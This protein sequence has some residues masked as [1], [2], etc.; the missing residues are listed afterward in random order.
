MAIDL[1]P[2]N[3][4]RY[5]TLSD[6]ADFTLPDSNWTWLALVQRN[7]ASA[8]ANYMLST[9][10]WGDANSFNLYVYG[11]GTGGVGVKV[12]TFTEAWLSGSSYSLTLDKW[13]WLYAVRRGGLLYG[14]QIQVGGSS[15]DETGGFSISGSQNS[16]IGP[17]IGYRALGLIRPWNGRWGEVAFIQGTGLTA[18]QMVEIANGG[19]LFSVAGPNI[20]F[21]LHGRNAADAAI[22]DL[23]SGHVATRQ[24]GSY[25][26]NEEDIETPYIW[27]PTYVR[28]VGGASHTLTVDNASQGNTASTAAITQAN[29][30]VGA[31]STQGN[32]ASASAITQAHVL[33]VAN[34]D[35]A[36]SASTPAVTLGS[37]VVLAASNAEQGNTAVTGAITQAHV[38]I[39]SP[40]VQDNVAAASAIVQAHVLAAAA[41]A[42]GNAA[43]DP[44][45]S[46]TVENDLAV[47]NATQGNIAGTGQITR[48]QTLTVDSATQNN[49]A[50]T[51]VISDGIIYEADLAN[52]TTDTAAIKK[53]G[54]PAN[55]QAWLR[56]TLEI[57]MGR[58]GNAIDVP[59]I[60]EMTFSA[61]PTKAECEML[62]ISLKRTRDSLNQLKNRFDT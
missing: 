61:T 37:A 3:S 39:H 12:S 45:I 25:G 34:G 53:P 23:I 29:A 21:L 13:Y 41:A 20:K 49:R 42:Q 40:S 19:Q 27:T 62:Y 58:R 30:L 32:T 55:T 7:G 60:P 35:Q 8:V 6:H 56:N 44:A 24:G 46:L 36:N 38:L 54:I 1:G 50:S 48:N 33:A 16:T 31:A 4:G 14:G 2:S 15:V 17:R 18:A 5:H 11:D 26:T 57:L 43:S 52:V 47:S 22:S 9:G 28:G 59:E 51:G 10:D